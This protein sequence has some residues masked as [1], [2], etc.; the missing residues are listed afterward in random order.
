V[1]RSPLGSV[2]TDDPLGADGGGMDRWRI[3]SAA[4]A[5][6]A[7][8]VTAGC[9]NLGVT[10]RATQPQVESTSTEERIEADGTPVDPADFEVVLDD[11]GRPYDSTLR[12]EPL[13]PVR[14][15]DVTTFEPRDGIVRTAT[16]EMIGY[17]AE[18]T[19]PSV[20]FEGATELTVR[21]IRVGRDAD[22]PADNIQG[23]RIDVPGSDVVRW[24]SFELAYG[25]DGG[26]GAVMT[27]EGHDRFGRVDGDAVL[28]DVGASDAVA[29]GPGGGAADDIV[30]FANGYGDGGFPMSRGVDA[31][32]RVVSLVI[33]DTTYPWRLA[34][35]DGIPPPDVTRAEDQLQ[36][37]L[38]GE[39]DLIRYVTKEGTEV[40]RDTTVC[41]IDEE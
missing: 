35:P 36:E 9:S 25:T 7:L 38:D 6:V 17:E 23:I 24:R 34:I 19:D 22:D 8:A 2:L 28:E 11:D 32:G 29:L 3:R 12:T 39:R 37:C 30:A 33:W 41:A 13:P 1:I 5:V 4:A 15:E 21:E 18:P 20:E 27:Q 16:G 10:T 14:M 40:V 31:G 26:M